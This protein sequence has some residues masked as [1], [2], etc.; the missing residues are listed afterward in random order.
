M[1]ISVYS[2]TSTILVCRILNFPGVQGFYEECLI[3]DH[4]KSWLSFALNFGLILFNLSIAKNPSALR[5]LKKSDLNLFLLSMEGIQ[6]N[7]IKWKSN[8]T[9]KNWPRNKIHCL[10]SHKTRKSRT[11]LHCYSFLKDIILMAINVKII[12]SI[13]HRLRQ[14]QAE[15]EPLLIGSGGRK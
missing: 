7:C 14:Y 9:R 15:V 8:E 6:N 5:K 10:S 13:I 4:W 12:K 11:L 3:Y 1:Q 2:D